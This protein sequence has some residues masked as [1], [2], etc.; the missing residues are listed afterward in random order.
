M[1]R[2]I[3]RARE[4][5]PRTGALVFAP[6]GSLRV[7]D[8]ASAPSETDEATGHRSALAVSAKYGYFVVACGREAVAVRTR[9]AADKA[10]AWRAREA[11]SSERALEDECVEVCERSANGDV[12]EIVSMTADERA[13][14]TCDRGGRVEFYAARDASDG[15]V[16]T[17]KFGEMM[18]EAPVRALKWCPNNSSFVAL[19]GESLV[20]ADR[21]GGELKRVAAEATSVSVSGDCALAWA[22]GCTVYIGSSEDPLGAPKSTI[23]IE[24]FRGPDDVVEVDG[25][26]AQSAD[27]VLLTA[28]SVAEP[29]DCF[30]SVLERD[31]EGW[32]CTRLEGAFDIDGSIVDLGGPVFNSFAFSPWN[33]AF[34][35]HRK[36]WDNQLLTVQ[37]PTDAEPCVLEVEDDRCFATVPMTDEDDNNYITGLGIDLTAAGGI[38]DNPQDKSA[39]SLAKGP[40]LIFSTTDGRVHMLKCASL[41]S[42]EA[43][44]GAA[45][46]RTQATLPAGLPPA[47]EAAGTSSAPLLAPA[48]PSFAFGSSSA[49]SFAASSAPSFSFAPPAS[50]KTPEPAPAP[51]FSLKP[52]EGSSASAFA[53]KPPGAVTPPTFSFQSMETPSTPTFSFKPAEAA[54]T[55]AEAATPAFSFKPAEA[56]KTPAEA[57]TPAFSFKPAEAAKTPEAAATPA[58]S[59]KPAE[60][61]KTPEAAATPAFSFKPAEAAKTQEAAATPAFSF[62]PA[63]AA[64][65]QEAAATPAFSFKPAEAAKTPAEAAT[66]AF[67]IKPAEAAKTPAE[68][69]TPAFSFK[70]AEAAKTPEPTFTGI[71]LKPIGKVS[72]HGMDISSLKTV[73]PSTPKVSFSNT[74]KSP[75]E[76]GVELLKRLTIGEIDVNTA[77]LEL[78]ELI[79]EATPTKSVKKEWVSAMPERFE[80]IDTTTSPAVDL[81]QSPLPAWGKRLADIKQSRE[82]QGTEANG[83]KAIEQDM[84]SVIAEVGAMLEDVVSVTKQLTGEAPD[85]SLPGKSELN[86]IERSIESVKDAVESL[87]SG[88]RTLRSRLNELWAANSADEALRSELESL[89]AAA[90]EEMDESANADDTRELS[91]ALKEVQEN[92]QKDMR[93]VLEMA[94]DLEASVEKLEAAKREA[95]RPK[96]KTVIRSGLV[97]SNSQSSKSATAQMNGIMKAISTQAAVIEAQAEKLDILL[98]RIEGRGIQR[99]SKQTTTPVK[100]DQPQKPQSTVMPTT[101]VDPVRDAEPLM[102]KTP[103]KLPVIE[104]SVGADIESII[105]S[106][107]ASTRVT[108]VKKSTPPSKPQQASPVKSPAVF[109]ASAPMAPVSAVE[110]KPAVPTMGFSADFLAKSQQGYAAAQKALEDDLQKVA[111]PTTSKS[112]F[113][114]TPPAPASSLAAQ[115]KPDEAT[116]SSGSKMGFSADFLAKASSGYQKAQAALEDELKGAKPVASTP[117]QKLKFSFAGASS[118]SSSELGAAASA[119]ASSGGFSF[120]VPASSAA[121]KAEGKAASAPAPASAP[122]FSFAPKTVEPK[123][124][125]PPSASEEDSKLAK[126]EAA[127]ET[128]PVAAPPMSFS[129]DFLAKAN[130][131]YAA[132]QKALEDDL[133]KAT[134]P[135]GTP[136]PSATELSSMPT[137]AL[138][139][140]APDSSIT[141]PKFGVLPASNAATS[142][143]DTAPSKPTFT[144]A[145]AAASASATSTSTATAGISAGFGS[146]GFGSSSAVASSAGTFGSSVPAQPAASTSAFGVTSNASVT[147]SAFGASSTLNSSGSPAASTTAFSSSNPSTGSK[148]AFVTSSAFGSS[149]SG[150]SGFGSSASAP[151]PFG[152]AASTSAGAFGKPS[153]FGTG[154]STSASTFGA[155]TAF[156]AATSTSTPAFGAPS[157]FG[158]STA[159]S[160][161]AFGAPSAFGAAASTSAP[162]FGAPAA[163]GSSTTT[164]FGAATSTSAPAFGAPSAFGAATATST[165]AFGATS[166]FG[167]A[168]SGSGFAAAANKP[169]AFGAAAA[170][171]ASAFGAPSGFGA[172]A[173]TGAPAFGAASGFGA[174]ATAGSGFAAAAT[175][176]SGFGAAATA[177]SGFAAAANKPSAFGAAAATNAPGFGTPSG[178]GG[179]GQSTG[180]FG[181]QQASSGFGQQ[182]ASGGFGQQASSGTFGQ[183]SSGFGQPSAFGASSGFGQS[184][185]GFAQ[186]SAFGQSQSPTGFG[187]PQSPSFGSNNP[188]FTQMRR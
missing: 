56:A 170:S 52:T 60:A 133:A 53:F 122:S 141:T 71:N 96:P 68:A 94:A 121:V 21:V 27:R 73:S 48:Q 61:A 159:P 143:V 32:V 47:M 172:A 139:F 6:V 24:P 58:F 103:V 16:K 95:N 92:M 124:E 66:P 169:S 62:K 10:A 142:A 25:L 129:A 72:P 84:T 130:S 114:F 101:K 145:P 140:T 174:A 64:K 77:E 138:S 39:P 108:T 168:V 86:K 18:L 15:K 117:E 109:A 85:R 160:T 179:F 63:E 41:N 38:M 34:V 182:Q 102:L 29:D 98:A 134:P 99:E 46:I 154:A 93:T 59:F 127:Q 110:A 42:T 89:I 135:P 126:Q 90:C 136:P 80:P 167:A 50:A 162:A 14:A 188:A 177:G 112:S 157:G 43:E 20:Y 12:I 120:G 164:S 51:A 171:G 151:S 4:G 152:A 146:F 181:Q 123:K 11:P 106:R 23:E 178:F 30:L 45:A 35:T 113:A 54:K 163:F 78:R 57:A 49:S 158:V 2:S 128:M 105:M 150:G 22:S 33:V 87:D 19:A 165:P 5:D 91:P 116:K 7:R 69:A 187:Q 118:T 107:V 166:G 147:I 83:L 131:G 81:R 65:T 1:T 100:K 155:P 75:V 37:L 9:E 79:L 156:G 82:Q 148:S 132:A 55:P 111:T 31:A 173:A 176:G 153:G 76:K 40:T 144:F 97:S 104:D 119:A 8:A 88:S 44:M 115:S 184:S 183:P 13:F 67:S 3:A 185:G 26:C 28:R 74:P 70:P 36:A 137:K 149:T 125:D 186:P 175:T 161:P 17:E 180:G